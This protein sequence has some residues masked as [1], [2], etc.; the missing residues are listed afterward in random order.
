MSQ[1]KKKARGDTP[2]YRA[3][4]PL[5]VHEL[6]PPPQLLATMINAANDYL[7]VY[8]IGECSAIV[9]REHGKWHLSIDGRTRYPTWLEI[10]AAWYRLIPGA[11]GI[12]GALVLPPLHEYVNVNEFCMQVLQIEGD[13]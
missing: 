6:P 12:A 7:R 8:L 2:S 5:N 9:T 4:R 10:S 1:R 13:S 3:A 11:E